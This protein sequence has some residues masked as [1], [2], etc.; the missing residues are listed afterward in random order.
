VVTPP[1]FPFKL[2]D[3][4]PATA[5]RRARLA[6]WVT[7]TEN[8]YFA[9]SY[10]NR[11]WSYL[12]GVGI[13][14]P[15]DDI[16]AG[17]PPTN[18]ELLERMTHE[19]I[20]SGFD[21]RKL[22]RTICKSRAYQHSIGTNRWNRDDE[23]NYSHA[24]ARRLP[25]EVLFDAIHR[26]TGSVTHLP[27]L[28]PG[29]RAAQLL[30]SNVEVPSD[31][32]GLFGKPPR[33][34]ACECERSGSMMLGPV[35]NLV[36][37]PIVGNALRDPDNRIAKLVMD[38]KDDAKVVEELFLAF[39]CRT[40]TPAEIAEG[41]KAVESADEEYQR[42]VGDYARVVNALADYEK[43]LPAKQA[44]WEK[45]LKDATAWTVLEAQQA[46]SAG[47]ATLAKQPDGS[48]L[49]KGK[50]RSPDVYTITAN[51]KLTG[52]TAVRLEALPDPSLPQQ[53]PGRASNGNFVLNE[54][55]I[56]AAPPGDTAPAKPV[57]LHHATADYSQPEWAV[58]GAIDGKPETGWAVD[59][60]YG[61]RHVAV[62][63]TKEPLGLT[64][65]TSLTF[66]LDQRYA[67]KDHN[68]GRFRLSVTTAKPP[69]SLQGPPEPVAKVLAVPAA[70]RT[71]AQKA[72]LANYYKSLDADWKRLSQVV[73]E[74]PRPPADKRQLGAQ[75]LAWALINTPGFLFN[76]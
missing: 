32:L 3:A 76:H 48:L 24:L 36:N 34:S 31:F 9:R 1:V 38:Q 67:G 26:A 69:V 51:T 41:I 73:A 5:S 68:L 22:E 61:K 70:K 10:V 28:P 60:Q 72:E 64:N 63:E 20:A 44:A 71:N 57:V 47:G 23:I 55:R 25:A 50:N 13:I 7:S 15:V 54:F 8:P 49:A 42:M 56:T 43:Q 2:H 39:Y 62:F 14:E 12:L 21:V 33:E 59:P 18:P 27:G 45:S 29:A 75:D 53:G 17:N 74:H 65:G 66:T 16:R 37:G 35:L 40:P 6:H 30:D 52:I 11:I 4:A 58:A 46:T 19:F